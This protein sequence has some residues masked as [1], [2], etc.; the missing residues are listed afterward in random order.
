MLL[1]KKNKTTGRK[2]VTQ[3]VTKKSK[4][5]KQVKRSIAKKM[6]KELIIKT[7]TQRIQNR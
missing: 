6:S 3:K 2:K 7:K 5:R 1:K 4:I